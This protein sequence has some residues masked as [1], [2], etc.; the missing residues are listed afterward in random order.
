MHNPNSR[1]SFLDFMSDITEN[2]KHASDA[3][4][5]LSSSFDES[6]D[7]SRTPTPTAPKRAPKKDPPRRLDGKIITH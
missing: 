2:L 7:S 4:S 5:S 1:K 3:V 6:E